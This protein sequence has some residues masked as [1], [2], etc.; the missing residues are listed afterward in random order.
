MAIMWKEETNLIDQEIKEML[1]KEA[2]SMADI[3]FLVRKRDGADRS[4]INLKKLN[5]GIPYSHFKMKRLF[6]LK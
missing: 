1:S 2:I 3:L 5:R 4:V 6:L